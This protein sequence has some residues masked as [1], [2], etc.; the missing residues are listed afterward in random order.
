[1]VRRDSVR[2]FHLFRLVFNH[3]FSLAGVNVLATDLFI[4]RMMMMHWID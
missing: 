2:R 3:K 4:D 1:M